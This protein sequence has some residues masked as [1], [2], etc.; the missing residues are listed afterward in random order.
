VFDKVQYQSLAVISAYSMSLKAAIS[1]TAKAPVAY[2]V[3]GASA[4]LAVGEAAEEA[5]L[6]VGE[7]VALPVEDTVLELEAAVAAMASAV[8]FRLP[9]SWLALQAAW[10]SAFIGFLATHWRYVSWQMKNGRVCAKAEESG[11]VA[12]GQT[13]LYVRVFCDTG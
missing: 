12:L 1:I 4:A 6:P 9:H 13:Q 5:A 2:V 8:A 3:I 10:P 7:L 11:T